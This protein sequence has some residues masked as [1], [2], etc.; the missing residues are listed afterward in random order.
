MIK[1]SLGSS[2]LKIV[3]K[4]GVQTGNHRTILLLALPPAKMVWDKARFLFF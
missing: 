4:I 1:G 3:E 2:L